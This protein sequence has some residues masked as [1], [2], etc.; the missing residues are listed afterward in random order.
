MVDVISIAERQMSVEDVIVGW[1]SFQNLDSIQRAFSEWFGIDFWAILRRRRRVG[2]R[3]VVL[4]TEFKKMIE[5][6]HGVIH[7]FTL[8]GVSGKTVLT[9]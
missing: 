7:R 8:T 6:R 4:A 1:Y 3:V 9:N 5:A 2:R